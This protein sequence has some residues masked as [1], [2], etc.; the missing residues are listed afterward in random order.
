VNYRRLPVVH[1][2][3][4]FG[5]RCHRYLSIPFKDA[6]RMICYMALF[7]SPATVIEH[8]VVSKLTRTEWILTNDASGVA[9]C[10][11]C[12]KNESLEHGKRGTTRRE[13][14]MMNSTHAGRRAEV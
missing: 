5:G 12:K 7:I 9:T 10:P 8:S 1:S 13:T 6:E 11:K 2:I 4:M 14:R 3:L